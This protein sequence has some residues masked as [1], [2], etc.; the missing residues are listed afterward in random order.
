MV[1]STSLAPVGL[2][3]D[4]VFCQAGWSALRRSSLKGRFRAWIFRSIFSGG[5]PLGRLGCPTSFSTRPFPC[6][7]RLA[8]ASAHVL[9]F[10][11]VRVQLELAGQIANRVGQADP[12]DLAARVEVEIG[13]DDQVPLGLRHGPDHRPAQDAEPWP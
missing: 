10:P 3:I 2:M 8:V 6:D 11:E 4:Q 13:V 5:S 7:D 9:E 12:G 1:A